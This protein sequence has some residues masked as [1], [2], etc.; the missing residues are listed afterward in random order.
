MDSWRILTALGNH[1]L[2]VPEPSPSDVPIEIR[3]RRS[4]G[5]PLP[6]DRVMLDRESGVTGILPRDSLF[7]RGTAN[8]RFQP[9]AANLTHLLIV[10]APEPAPSVDLVHR[11]IAAACMQNIKPVVIVNKADLGVPDRPPFTHLHDLEIDV[12]HTCCTPPMD[13]DGLKTMLHGG[14][15]LLAGQSGVGKS[16][17][18]NALLP[19]L[20]L[21]T[22][23]LSRSTGKGR[24]TT[25]GARLY[26]LP[27]NGWLIDTPGVWEYGLWRMTTTELEQGFPEF[28]PFRGQC[29]FRDCSHCHEPAC[30]IRDA[31][32]T[33]KL[34][35]CRYQA[36][37]N[38]LAEQRRLG[39]G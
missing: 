34:P 10:I 24:H 25:T 3:F 17:L 31:V 11:Y 39:L 9:M 7:G 32:G 2:A 36:W 16:S 4:I 5:R 21:Q 28:R 22:N 27:D 26:H 29:R 37:L 12:L 15:H 20:A 8:G 14:V 6:G 35:D 23:R 30:A 13:L 19:D 18:T 33:G 38:L 1:G